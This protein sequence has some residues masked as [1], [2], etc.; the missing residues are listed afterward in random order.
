M[1]DS[2]EDLEDLETGGPG[3]RTSARHI[4]RLL[5]DGGTGPAGPGLQVHLAPLSPRL[6]DPYLIQDSSSSRS[7]KNWCRRWDS[8]SLARRAAAMLLILAKRPLTP[9]RLSFTW[10]VSK[11]SLDIRL[12]A[13]LFRS[14]SRSCREET[15]TQ[16]HV[17]VAAVL[18]A[19]PTAMEEASGSA[20]VQLP[21]PDS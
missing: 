18:R 19:P 9:L 5:V 7:L 12:S 16:S 13:W 15:D 21:G 3:S 6:L 8:F 1:W 11:A 17:K 2:E 10:D 20:G 14:F 4:Q